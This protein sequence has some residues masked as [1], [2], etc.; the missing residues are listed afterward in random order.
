MLISNFCGNQGMK[1]KV[2][3]EEQDFQRFISVCMCRYV[4]RNDRLEKGG[5][6]LPISGWQ[7][8]YFNL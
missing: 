6:Q 1:K 7:V 5:R 3:D 2:K 4:S 8:S